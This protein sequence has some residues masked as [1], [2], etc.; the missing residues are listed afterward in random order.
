MMA[1]ASRRQEF[2]A[3]RLS[4]AT[5]PQVL[6]VVAAEAVI[7][8]FIG[9]L[10]GTVAALIALAGVVKGLRDSIPDTPLV[11]PLPVLGAVAGVCLALGLVASLVPARLILRQSALGDFTQE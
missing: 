5:V 4:G 1:T 7:V 6:R 8:V 10:L 2:A 9:T 11:L 3:L